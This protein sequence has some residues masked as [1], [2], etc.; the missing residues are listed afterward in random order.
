MARKTGRTPAEYGIIEAKG[1]KKAFQYS[2]QQYQMLRYPMDLAI[3]NFMPFWY[4]TEFKQ[5]GWGKE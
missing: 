3:W 2:D 4:R 1:E 5:S